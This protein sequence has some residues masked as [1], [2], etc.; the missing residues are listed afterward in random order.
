M[1]RGGIRPEQVLVEFDQVNQPLTPFFWIE[2][3]RTIRQ[4]RSAQY[5]LVF[6]ERANFLFVLRSARQP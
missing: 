2:L 5:D 4:L 1:L 6:R 3:L